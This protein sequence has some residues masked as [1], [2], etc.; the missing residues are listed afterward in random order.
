MKHT[1]DTAPGEIKTATNVGEKAIKQQLAEPPETGPAM[2]ELNADGA[3]EST[4]V[5]T[6]HPAIKRAI[7]VIK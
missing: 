5:T 3:E 7:S 2:T 4:L 6:V 1:Q